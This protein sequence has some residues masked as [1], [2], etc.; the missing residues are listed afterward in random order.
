M[1]LLIVDDEKRLRDLFKILCEGAGYEVETAESPSK[2]L[3]IIEQNT[4]D[5]AFIDVRMPEMDGITLMKRLR[6]THPS[7]EVIIITAHGSIETAVDAMRE[8]AADF[9]QK[10]FGSDELQAAIERTT[11]FHQI[12]HQLRETENELTR[13]RHERES[14]RDDVFVGESSAVKTVLDMVDK[15][16]ANEKVNVLITG[17]SGTGKE[18]IARRLHR[19]GPRGE[20]P[21]FAVNCAAIVETLFESEFFGHRKGAFTGANT[22]QPGWFERAHG[23]TLFLDEITEIPVHLQAKLLRVLE[24]HVVTRVGETQ[25]RPIDVR[26]ISSSNQPIE[27]IVEEGKFRQDL[28]FRLNG[29][30]LHLPALREHPDDIPLLC[31]HFLEG[32][33]SHMTKHVSSVTPDAVQE[34]QTYSF[35]GNVRELKNLTERAVILSGGDTLKSFHLP[36]DHS[37][38]TSL[39]LQKLEERTIRKAM[40][41]AGDNKTLAAKLLGISWQALHRKLKSL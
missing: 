38:E 9:I 26:I 13:V 17:E 5:I 40:E 37:T 2:A 10:P 24:E 16:A 1:K 11:R 6:E 36:D 7:L 30:R 41:Q 18:M 3:Q 8:G 12:N 4:F 31:I 20:K 21:F 23:S 39:N 33:R 29:F 22:D 14:M 27:K 32:L 28:F 35:P 15:L 25:S 34:L 19:L